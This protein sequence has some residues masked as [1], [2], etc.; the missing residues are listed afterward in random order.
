MIRAGQLQLPVMVQLSEMSMPR[1][2]SRK[3]AIIGWRRPG[4]NLLIDAPDLGAV[5]PVGLARARTAQEA[6]ADDGSPRSGW[7]RSAEAFRCPDLERRAFLVCVG[8]RGGQAGRLF[9]SPARD[10]R[11]GAAQ[12]KGRG[13]W[14]WR[15][16]CSELGQR[17]TGRRWCCLPLARERLLWAVGTPRNQKVPS[18]KV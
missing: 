2:V 5:L 4:D 16:S 17:Q 11:H 8:A 6:A 14:V 10:Q 9:G 3:A 18:A 7:P 15:Q 1:C 13:R 12:K